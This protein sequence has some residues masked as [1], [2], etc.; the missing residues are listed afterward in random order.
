MSLFACTLRIVQSQTGIGIIG[1]MK[2]WILLT[3]EDDKRA[4]LQALDKAPVGY[5]T[6]VFAV[7]DVHAELNKLSS[8]NS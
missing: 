7:P 6:E 3:S 5:K 1:Q 2:I 4:F 8:P